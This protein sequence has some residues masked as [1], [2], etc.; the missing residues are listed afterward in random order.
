MSVSTTT[1][2]S[3]NASAKSCHSV[4]RIVAARD[5]QREPTLRTPPLRDHEAAAVAPTRAL[6]DPVVRLLGEAERRHPGA[7][8]ERGCERIVGGRDARPR[9]RGDEVVEG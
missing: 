5:G 9:H 7:R 1:S 3:T 8:R 6:N 2:A 4:E